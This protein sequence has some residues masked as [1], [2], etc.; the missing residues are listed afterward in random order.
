MKSL[1]DKAMDGKLLTTD[2]AEE[3]KKV[4]AM[5]TALVEEL[6]H[7]GFLCRAGLSE[8]IYAK[9]LANLSENA[10]EYLKKMDGRMYTNVMDLTTDKDEMNDYNF[11]TNLLSSQ[12]AKK[13]ITEDQQTEI[14]QMLHLQYPDLDPEEIADA[15]FDYFPELEY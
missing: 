12:C 2:L 8:N 13:C 15:V 10:I 3:S 6:D 14:T 7:F 9:E 5:I 11:V 1:T 4:S